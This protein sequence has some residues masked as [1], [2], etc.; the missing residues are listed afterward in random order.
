MLYNEYL[1]NNV[2]CIILLCSCIL[3]KILYVSTIMHINYI[4]DKHMIA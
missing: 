3:I 4:I 2:M 1:H